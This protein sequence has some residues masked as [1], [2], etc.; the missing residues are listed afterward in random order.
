MS[1][2]DLFALGHNLMPVVKFT[3]ILNEDDTRTPSNEVK[4]GLPQMKVIRFKIVGEIFI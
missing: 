4:S 2:V 3:K 1:R